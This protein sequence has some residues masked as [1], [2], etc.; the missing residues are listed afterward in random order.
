[1]PIAP[2][3]HI[4]QI[5]TLALQIKRAPLTV[6]LKQIQA[7]EALSLE[8]EDNSLYP[9]D[10]VVYRITKYRG[11]EQVQPMLMGSAL[12]GDLVATVAIVSRT[13]DLPAKGTLTINETAEKLGVSPRTVCR[14]RKEGLI[15][16]WVVE[17]SGRR[18][19]G[20]SQKMLSTFREMHGERLHSASKFSR[21]SQQEQQDIV[22]SAM[23]YSGSGRSLSDIAAE[24]ANTTGRGHET[25]RTLLGRSARVSQQLGKP[26]PLTRKDARVIER[27]ILSGVPWVLLVKK[28]NRSTDSLRKV[29]AR[30][31]AT[32]LKQMNITHVELDVFARADAEDIILGAPAALN[33]EP[34]VLQ[35]DPIEFG[36]TVFKLSKSEE[37]AVVSAMHLLRRRASLHS[38]QLGYAPRETVLDRIETD[39]RWSFLLQQHL[40]RVALPTAIAVAVQ[41]VG[42]SL[43][44][45]PSSET[46]TLMKEVIRTVADVCSVLNPSI[47]QTAQRTPA[48]VLDRYFSSSSSTQVSDR[49]AARH[50]SPVFTCP[51]HETVPWANLIPRQDLPLIAQETSQELAELVAMRF[52]WRGHPRTIDEIANETLRNR[53]WVKRQ[54]RAW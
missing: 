3:F 17:S 32:R 12:I 28:F 35:F 4:E 46:S 36:N 44:E 53:M 27:A 33:V 6:R 37:I 45:L 10:Y 31:R 54:L 40:I 18:R 50:R 24:L 48:A 20:C 22:N 42:R 15:F 8:I 29:V 2:R 23:Q 13:L 30:L 16:R 38:Q 25:I 52:G 26:S 39:L 47:G 14:L 34:P 21:L 9:L 1:M 11:D 43:H 5:R 41:H 7:V 51:F 49:A 19:I